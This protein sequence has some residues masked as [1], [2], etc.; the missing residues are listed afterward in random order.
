MEAK[1]I[2][3]PVY[4]R[5]GAKRPRAA[6][7][8]EMSI[9]QGD[10]HVSSVVPSAFDKQTWAQVGAHEHTVRTHQSRPNRGT[11]AKYVVTRIEISG[12]IATIV[13]RSL[14]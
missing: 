4:P 6:S 12:A 14:R 2:L 9:F 10:R 1:L 13:Y 8:T 11:A 5:M 3:W 7:E